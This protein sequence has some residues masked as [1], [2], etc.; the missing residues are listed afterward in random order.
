MVFNWIWGKA[1]FPRRALFVYSLMTDAL[2]QQGDGTG[3]SGKWSSALWLNC[4]NVQL[5]GMVVEVCELTAHL[6]ESDQTL[7]PLST[8]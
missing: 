1:L 6:E 7:C 3:E 8:L 2:A 4:M 5:S